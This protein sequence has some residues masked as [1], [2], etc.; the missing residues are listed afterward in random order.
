MRKKLES[1]LVHHFKIAERLFYTES[2]QQ[3][4]PRLLRLVVANQRELTRII[5]E[6]FP[7][8][9]TSDIDGSIATL[10]A[11]EQRPS[12]AATKRRL[13]E[14]DARQAQEDAASN[15]RSTNIVAPPAVT[16]RRRRTRRDDS[17]WNRTLPHG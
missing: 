13:K 5:T 2:D 1:F 10:S 6:Q 7:D 14:T 8:T 11:G 9:M 15:K 12:E 3:L 4:L 16:D 17:R